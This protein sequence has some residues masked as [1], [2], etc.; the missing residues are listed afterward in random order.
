METKEFNLEK[1]TPKGS[2]VGFPKEVILWMLDNQE[3]QGNERN[4]E[5]FEKHI[6]ADDIHGGFFGVELKKGGGLCKNYNR[7]GL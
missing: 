5:V 4:V 2:L 1:Y 6:A 7:K 3:A